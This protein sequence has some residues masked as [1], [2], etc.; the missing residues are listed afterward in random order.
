MALQYPERWQKLWGFSLDDPQSSF[1][2]SMRL[3]RENGWD[4][5]YA[6]R[7]IA[8]YKKFIYLITLNQGTLTPSDAVDQV[9]HLHLIYTRSYWDLLCSEILG[10][11]IHHGPTKGGIQEQQKFE[12]CYQR[13]L[14]LYQ[15]EFEEPAPPDIW[16]PLPERFE[17]T[18]FQRIDLKKYWVIPI[19]RWI[20]KLL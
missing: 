18:R 8:E 5:Q 4:T 15:S 14:Q 6:L 9:W 20:Q 1:P 11:E 3:A 19:P 17:D 16:L 10:I 7:C 2:F 13:T 12:Q